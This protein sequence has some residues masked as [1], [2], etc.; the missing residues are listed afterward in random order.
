MRI[1]RDIYTRYYRERS[2]DNDNFINFGGI[3]RFIIIGDLYGGDSA[4]RSYNSDL[5]NYRNCEIMWKTV[6]KEEGLGFTPSSFLFPY[7]RIKHSPL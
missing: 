2:D 4:H 7:S 5:S 3:I 1:I 6:F